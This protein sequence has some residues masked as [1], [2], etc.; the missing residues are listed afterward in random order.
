MTNATDD[1]LMEMMIGK[2]EP[3]LTPAPW[4]PLALGASLQVWAQAGSAS[5]SPVPSLPDSSGNGRTLTS[6]TNP[7]TW[8]ATGAANNQPNLNFASAASLQGLGTALFDAGIRTGDFAFGFVIRPTAVAGLTNDFMGYGGIIPSIFT[9]G[10]GFFDFR[11]VGSFGAAAVSGTW[12]SGLCQ[13][14]SGV[15]ELWLS[16][17]K[18]PSTL[19]YTT[20][21]GANVFYVGRGTNQFDLNGCDLPE[22]WFAS[23]SLGAVDRAGWFAYTLKKY[24][25]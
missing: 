21:I 18:A 23:R 9:S 17:V 6:A 20:S 22:A 2:G 7:P 24:G 11:A 10:T 14:V 13:R 12:Y 3:I 15:L 4:T 19:S 1:L 8:S 25:V 5:A 16:N